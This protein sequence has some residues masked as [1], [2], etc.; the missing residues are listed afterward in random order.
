LQ[1]IGPGE[2]T[3]L[4]ANLPVGPVPAKLCLAAPDPSPR[5]SGDARY[6]LRFANATTVTQKWAAGQFCF[7]P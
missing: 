3:V 5:L 6:A 7:T 2:T 4:T 1:S